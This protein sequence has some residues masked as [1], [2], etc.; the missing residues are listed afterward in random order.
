[1]TTRGTALAVRLD[2]VNKAFGRHQVL[3]DISW[4]VP[5]G[6]IVG[7]LGLNGAGKTSLLRILLGLA[8]P[9]HGTV[10]IDGTLLTD[11]TPELRERVGYV[12]ERPVIPS[13]FTANRLEAVGRRA[14][15][16]W[17]ANQYSAALDRF[18][19]PR[20]KP[21]YVM[22][23][24]QRTLTALAFALAH[25]ADLLLLDEPTNGLDPV[26]RR[27]FL[28]NLIEESYDE[29]RTVIV[30]S[31]RLE[32]VQHIAQDIAVLHHGEMVADGAL[33][34][35][36]LHDRIL[37]W[38]QDTASDD[39]SDLPGARR[40]HWTDKQAAVYVRNFDETAIQAAME[41]RGISHWTV[42]D[43]SLDEFFEERVTTDV[44]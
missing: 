14:F 36:L 38:R 35:L 44:G 17:D 27:E 32:E 15:P 16:S 20:S 3:R 41:A 43:V 9:S 10:E 11:N 1:M 5:K 6:Y 4:T 23:Q 37:S 22:S 42:R 33:D 19:I 29:G 28:S 34:D 26:I 30:S 39:V 40:A 2:S 24:G 31:H 7:L 12:P 8:S 25:H 13:A 21:M 18:R